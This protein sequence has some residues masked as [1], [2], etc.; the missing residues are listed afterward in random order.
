M[1]HQLK[2]NGSFETAFTEADRKHLFSLLARVVATFGTQDL[3]WF[4]T[5]ETI[6]NCLFSLK[7]RI[8]HEYAKNFL[9]QIVYRMFRSRTA[10]EMENL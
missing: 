3:E 6:L 9:N 7:S 10:E 5:C 2:E 4:C 8:S 1:Q